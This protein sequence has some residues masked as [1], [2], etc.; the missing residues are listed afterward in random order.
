MAVNK[1]QIA[2]ELEKYDTIREKVL[3]LN[4]LDK[5][6]AIIYGVD[7]VKISILVTFDMNVD[8]YVVGEKSRLDII[9]LICKTNY[10]YTYCSIKA[11]IKNCN[12]IKYYICYDCRD[13]NY[14]LCATCLQESK[15]CAAITKIKITF[16]LCTNKFTK[17]TIPK[18]IRRLITN[19]F[20]INFLN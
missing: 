7:Y 6:Y 10:V 2:K 13:K 14:K 17:F 16:W 18:D 1:D 5:Y 11:N 8:V 12:T 19:L 20:F 15:E 4:E 3:R 9:C